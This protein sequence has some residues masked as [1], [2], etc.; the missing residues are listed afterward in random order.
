MAKNIHAS[1][2]ALGEDGVVFQG[3]SGCGQSDLTLRMIDEGAA[4]VSDDYV[5]ISAEE[6][7]TRATAPPT[8]E[9]LI[10]VRGLGL[11]T[12]PYVSD[13]RVALVVELID[14]ADV[15]RLPDPDDTHID[16][17][18]DM[19]V[20]LIRL[21]AYDPSTAAKIRLAIRALRDGALRTSL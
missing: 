18:P 4:L 10:E 19:P 11:I 8:I 14:R 5:L 16:L 13:I 20:P 7:E 2:I 15:P 17:L 3:P 1:C 9:G 21:T 12:V 6:G